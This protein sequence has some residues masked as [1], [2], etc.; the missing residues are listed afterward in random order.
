[1]NG[2]KLAKEKSEELAQA[3]LLSKLEA[4]RSASGSRL[5]SYTLTGKGV[6][7]AKG[8]EMG[9]FQMGST[10]ALIFECPPGYHIAKEDGDALKLG[11]ALLVKK[12]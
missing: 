9:M 5:L 6:S 1:M 2:F 11:D 4:P 12:E 8:E 10:I 3:E 7:L